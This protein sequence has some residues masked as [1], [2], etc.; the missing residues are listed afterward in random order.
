MS[1]HACTSS[2]ELQLSSNFWCRKLSILVGRAVWGSKVSSPT[3]L[4]PGNGLPEA[5]PK[6]N[7]A[8][9]KILHSVTRGEE[10]VWIPYAQDLWFEGAEWNVTN[11][12]LPLCC[13][14]NLQRNTFR[15]LPLL[16]FTVTVV[17]ETGALKIS[18]TWFPRF[19]P[20]TRSE[21]VLQWPGWQQKKKPHATVSFK[22]PNIYNFGILLNSITQST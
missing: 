22:N 5:S 7:R 21:A 11:A 16:S 10:G 1:S 2:F 8:W 3:S 4:V 9:N 15:F 6:C 20:H 19:S 17:R 13:Q 18:F 14:N 12:P